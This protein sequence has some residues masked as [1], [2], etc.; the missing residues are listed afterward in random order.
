MSR[1]GRSGPVISLFSFQDIITSVTAIVTVIALL[2]ALDLVQR[3]QAQSDDSSG[4][5]A[6]ELTRRLEQVTTELA[7][8]RAAADSTDELV[9]E[10]AATSSAEL[11]NEIAQRESAIAE[12]ERERARLER[13]RVTWQ[14]REKTERAEQFDLEPVRRQ[15][16]QVASETVELE[17]RTEQ[18]RQDDRILFT[19]AR[20]S[21]REGW[22]V[23]ID[24]QRIEAAP[25]GRPARPVAFVATGLPVLGTSAA[26]AFGNWIDEQGHR[27]AYFLLLVRPDASSAFD[28]VQEMLTKKSVSHGFDLVGADQA[29]LDPERGAAP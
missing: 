7:E 16:A 6:A 24:S 25:L 13:Q 20:G 28:D 12:L 26:E 1:R 9:R 5:L 22:L 4:A 23:V 18:E 3:K 27:S 21:N 15:Q 11:R 10:V 2:L 14:A 29:L 8:L 19:M 17:R